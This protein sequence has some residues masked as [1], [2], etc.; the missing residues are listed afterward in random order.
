MITKELLQNCIKNINGAIEH[1]EQ[2]ELTNATYQYVNMGWELYL[3]KEYVGTY[4]RLKEIAEYLDVDIRIVYRTR[5]GV[6]TKIAK[7]GY[8]L[9]KVEPKGDYYETN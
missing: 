3:D 8:T 2:K 6:H 4:I 5:E 1:T 9:K 7:M